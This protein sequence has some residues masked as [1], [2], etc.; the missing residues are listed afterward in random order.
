ML[1]ILEKLKKNTHLNNYYLV[2]Q[3]LSF[4]LKVFVDYK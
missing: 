2:S 3:S 4:I 1:E